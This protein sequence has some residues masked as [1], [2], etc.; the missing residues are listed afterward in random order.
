MIRQAMIL[1][2]GLSGAAGASQAPT[3]MQQYTQRLGGAEQALSRV[4]ADFTADAASEGLSLDT[5]L[6][7]YRASPDTFLQKRGVSM[8]QTL[9]RYTRISTHQRAL[10]EANA[11]ERPLLLWQYRDQELFDGMLG[12]YKPAIPTTSE[13]AVYA[14]AGFVSGGGLMAMLLGGLG[15]LRRGR[16]KPTAA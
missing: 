9:D 8:G 13:G 16:R 10:S 3:L 4:V 5:A 7:R 15:R 11:I 1:V 2:A 14:F 12:D 6:S